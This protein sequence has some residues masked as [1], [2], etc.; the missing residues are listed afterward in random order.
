[1]SVLETPSRHHFW[2][3][4]QKSQLAE[5]LPSTDLAIKIF[6]SC[7]IRIDVNIQ[8][9]D[10]DFWVHLS[11]FPAPELPVLLVNRWQALAILFMIGLLHLKR[12]FL[13]TTS[14]I[15]SFF[16]QIFVIALFTL[17]WCH[18]DGWFNKFTFMARS[19]LW[20]VNPGWSGLDNLAGHAPLHNR[21][22]KVL[23]QIS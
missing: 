15:L 10:I 13:I 7:A 16:M 3:A 20:R 6:L 11:R 1:M 18:F 8:I 19:A 5:I 23:S 17:L 22:N 12:L 21:R 9:I 14:L 4:F 2:V